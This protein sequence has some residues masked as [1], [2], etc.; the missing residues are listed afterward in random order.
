MLE[1]IPAI[2]ETSLTDIEGQLARVRGT[3]REVQLDVGD[4]IF[5]QNK[6]WPFTNAAQRAEF[7]RITAQ[8]EG[9]PL[10]EDFD[11]EVDLMIQSPEANALAWVSAGA[12]RIILHAAS[13][14]APA[15]ARALQGARGEEN[16]FPVKVGIALA[17]S[18]QAADLEPFEG[19]YDFVQVMGIERVGFQGQAFDER[20]V[21]LVAQLRQMYRDLTIQVDGGVTLQNARSLAQAGANRLIVGSDIFGSSDP[22]KEIEALRSEANKA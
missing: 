5:V 9:L 18:A 11:F 20:T 2:L 4:G 12:S 7:D 14:G 21:A 6:T 16:I 13:D 8:E 1:I 22:K 10:W 17:S 3:A 15:A 19:L